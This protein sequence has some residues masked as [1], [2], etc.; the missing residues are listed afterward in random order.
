LK[1]ERP[2]S[3]SR[4]WNATRIIPGFS[5]RKPFLGYYLTIRAGHF[6]WWLTLSE[7]LPRKKALT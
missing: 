1:K 6:A 7:T 3:P 5:V 2:G 4:S